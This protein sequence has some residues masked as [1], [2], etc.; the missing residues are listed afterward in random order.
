MCISR[1]GLLALLILSSLIFVSCSS[2]LSKSTKENTIKE[3]P[4]DSIINVLKTI[5]PYSFKYN[6]SEKD[7]QDSLEVFT[8]NGMSN[9][10]LIRYSEISYSSFDTLNSQFIR[11]IVLSFSSHDYA[12]KAFEEAEKF[13][14]NKDLWPG[15]FFMLISLSGTNFIGV[16]TSCNT[17]SKSWEEVKIELLDL[18]QESLYWQI[19]NTIECICL[20]PCKILE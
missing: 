18:I 9:H 6:I 10:G 5:W 2:Y 11:I 20:T 4:H 17:K 13:N 3:I 19:D 16:I 1:N 7:I 15:R 14:V 12:L 8:F